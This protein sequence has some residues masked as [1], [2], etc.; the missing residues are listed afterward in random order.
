MNHEMQIDIDRRRFV[1]TAAMTLAA[2]GLGLFDVAV[3]EAEGAMGSA[4]LP[5]EGSAPSLDGATGW[6]NSPPL[7]RSQ[8][9][10]KVVL[11]DFCTYTCINWLRQ[12][13]YVRAWAAKYKDKGL[14]VIGAHTPEFPFER[15]VANIER[16]MKAMRVEYPIAIDSD[17]GV[18]RAFDNHYWPALYFIDA[19]GRIRHH[20]FGEGEYEQSEAVLQQLL[21]DAGASG[22][23]RD[24]VQVDAKGIEAPADWNNV[25]TG[26]NYVGSERTEGFSSPGGAAVGK[27][28]VYAVPAKLS[29]NRWALAGDWTVGKLNI[30]LNQANGRIAY[31]F[32]ARDLHLVM[33]P[34]AGVAS[35]R[36]RVLIDGQPPREAHGGDV[37][38][39]G[40]GMV[41]E[42]RLHQL[43]R[44]RGAIADRQ[45][46]IEFLDA[47]VEAFSFTFG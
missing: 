21:T 20:V 30:A 45:F 40:N 41:S 26:E 7:K 15:N 14:V 5:V 33:G 12:L 38:E 42:Q 27:S 35:V 16:A 22:I 23:G 1:G 24:L 39:D 28:R 3:R 11:V 4:S 19:K 18:W 47:G 36:F 43:I 6:L 32:H 34:A 8:L 37:D 13:P 17:Y 25:K 10:G 44:Q 2:A 9:R 31:R 46:E 29:L